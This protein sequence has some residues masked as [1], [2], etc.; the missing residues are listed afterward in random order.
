MALLIIVFLILIA[1]GVLLVAFALPDSVWK[2]LLIVVP[3][4]LGLTL[5]IRNQFNSLA[6]EKPHLE[7][8]LV[9]HTLSSNEPN[10][11]FELTNTGRP[12]VTLLQYTYKTPDFSDGVDLSEKMR[13]TIPNWGTINI[14]GKLYSGILSIPTTLDLKLTYEIS[15]EPRKAVHSEYRFFIDRLVKPQ[16]RL[17]A[18]NW[19]DG[20]GKIDQ[21]ESQRRK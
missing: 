19:R 13:P 12:Q 7:A 21:T 3:G 10:F 9:I 18:I 8:T 15:D 4:I 17:S 20:V 14:P 16:E 6:L 5:I 1:A 2:Y 11:H